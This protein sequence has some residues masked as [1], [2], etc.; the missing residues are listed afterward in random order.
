MISAFW[1]TGCG[2]RYEPGDLYRDGENKGIVIDTDDAG[3]VKLIMSLDEISGID[4]DS[5]TKWATSTGNGWRLPTKNEIE[6][7]RKYKALSNKTLNRKKMPPVLS[8]HTFYWTSTPC[9]ES[10]TYA[11]GPDGTKCYFSTNASV[12]YRARAVKEI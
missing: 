7:I 6:K 1:A 5:A 9:S 8:G 2:Y 11:C 4:A 12:Q 3:N 10:H